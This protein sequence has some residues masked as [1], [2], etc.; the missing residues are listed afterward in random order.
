MTNEQ[1]I[2]KLRRDLFPELRCESNV[3]LGFVGLMLDPSRA[4][5]LLNGRA[6]ILTVSEATLGDYLAAYHAGEAS[7]MRTRQQEALDQMREQLRR[8]SE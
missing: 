3:P 6:V 1:L 8:L 2:E 5:Y 4:R 7:E